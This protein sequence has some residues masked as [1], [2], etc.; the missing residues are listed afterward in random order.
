MV[1]PIYINPLKLAPMFRFGAPESSFF[2]FTFRFGS[3]IN[4]IDQVKPEAKTFKPSPIARSTL[5]W[6]PDLEDSVPDII[7]KNGKRSK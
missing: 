1:S 3:S 2:P 5:S 6:D 4:I 7:L